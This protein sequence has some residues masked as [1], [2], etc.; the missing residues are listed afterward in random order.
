M[1]SQSQR[2][3]E[4]LCWES[5]KKVNMDRERCQNGDF[6]KGVYD[7]R[8]LCCERGGEWVRWLPGVAIATLEG[9]GAAHQ[10]LGA[11]SVAAQPGLLEGALAPSSHLEGSRGKWVK[12]VIMHNWGAL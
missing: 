7:Q 8:A 4:L 2:R 5:G 6:A 3:V 1:S 10:N 9:F 12:V 11:T